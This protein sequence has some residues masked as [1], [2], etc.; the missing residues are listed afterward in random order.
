[1]AVF[2]GRFGVRGRVALGTRQLAGGP[3]KGLMMK[4]IIPEQAVQ[5]LSPVRI[6]AIRATIVLAGNTGRGD[7]FGGEEDST[8]C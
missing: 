4:G 7:V 6:R 8:S 2:Q 3:A 5:D 1:M